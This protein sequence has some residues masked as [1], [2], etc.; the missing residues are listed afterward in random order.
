MQ[1]LVSKISETWWVDMIHLYGFMYNMK[2]TLD[3]SDDLYAVVKAKAALE[4]RTLR[5]I[6]EELLQGWVGASGNAKTEQLDEPR[7][8]Y[9]KRGARA[10]KLT[11]WEKLRRKWERE[12][13][14]NAPI[15]SIAGT[16]KPTEGDAWEVH[17]RH[18]RNIMHHPRSIDEIAG[19][20]TE[21][22][23]EMDMSKIRE[24]YEQKLGEEW[25]RRHP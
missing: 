17:R 15:S 23:P 11:P 4:G 18:L 19:M 9:Q 22:G 3:L 1:G 12:N 16:I 10:Q 14:P 20:L 2:T 6:V 21:P 8:K 13:N 5:S 7:A 25:K 24:I